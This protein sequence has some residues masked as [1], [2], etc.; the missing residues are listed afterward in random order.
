MPT[1][2][3]PRRA[4]PAICGGVLSAAKALPKHR[5]I[6]L[7]MGRIG[8][9]HAPCSPRLRRRVTTYAAP[10]TRRH[11]RRAG[12]SRFLRH[13]YRVEKLGK[14]AKIYGVI[15]DPV[16]HSISPR[17][18]NR[19][20]HRNGLDAVYLPFW[21]RAG[22]LRDFFSLAAKLPLSG[23]SVNHP[24]QAED[25]PLPGRSRAAGAPYRRPSIPSGARPASG[26]HHTTPPASPARWRAC[27]NLPIQCG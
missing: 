17:R 15:A 3:S 12:E 25:H 22:C 8:F 26:A 14:S 24:P 16:R 4:S 19:A 27:S 20:F 11:R 5:L 13:L 6:V 23:F 2:S 7:A 1:R 18:H 10:C 21:S 9:P